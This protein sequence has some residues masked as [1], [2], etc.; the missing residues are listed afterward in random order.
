MELPSSPPAFAWR[1]CWGRV[2]D[3]PLPQS[4]RALCLAGEILVA[5]FAAVADSD[6]FDAGRAQDALERHDPFVVFV[7]HL[8]HRLAVRVLGRELCDFTPQATVVERLHLID[9]VRRLE[10]PR[11]HSD[12]LLAGQADVYRGGVSVLTF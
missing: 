1:L 10:F 12:A 7:F 11:H 2:S 3:P 9:R 6:E 8:K 4:E 5:F